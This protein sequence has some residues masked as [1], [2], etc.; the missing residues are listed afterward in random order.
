MFVD[1]N[2]LLLSYTYIEKSWF[3]KLVTLVNGKLNRLYIW[4]FQVPPPADDDD[5][6]DEEI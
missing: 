5:D 6:D 2:W 1:K 4:A 3:K